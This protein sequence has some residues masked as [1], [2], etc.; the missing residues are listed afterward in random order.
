M[1]EKKQGPLDFFLKA[2]RKIGAEAFPPLA[3]KP[4]SK[5]KRKYERKKAKEEWGT[6]TLEDSEV[7]RLLSHQLLFG[8]TNIFLYL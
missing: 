3:S 8:L 1:T 4:I 7:Q 6:V 5:A 2:P